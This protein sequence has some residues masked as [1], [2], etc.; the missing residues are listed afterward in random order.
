MNTK[1][2]A[3]K[4]Q[5]Q[6]AR[7]GKEYRFYRA[8]KNA[9]GEP[10]RPPHPNPLPGG[11]GIGEKVG[12]VKGLYHEINYFVKT[13]TSEAA[14]VRGTRG[15]PIK[16]PMILCLLESVKAA[17]LLFGDTTVINGKTFKVTGVQNIQEWGIIASISLEV[18]DDGFTV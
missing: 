10:D 17:D 8:G 18:V 16:Q 5:R 7:S 13:E 4:L 2:E 15:R 1:F 14:T 3:F 12:S 6:L 11:E 9:F